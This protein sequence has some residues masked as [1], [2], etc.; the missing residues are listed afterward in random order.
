L[1][2]LDQR[3]FPKMALLGAGMLALTTVVGV[4]AHQLIKHFSPTAEVADYG[5]QIQA[6]RLRFIDQGDGISSFGGHVRVFDATTGRELAQLKESDGFVRAVLNSLA[7]ERTRSGAG[8]DTVFE[9]ASWSSH[10][11]TLKDTATGASVSL[12]QFGAGNTAAFLRF[13][14]PAADGEGDRRR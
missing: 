12:G 3:P 8:G 14:D 5:T 7:F 9:L 1:S 6:R 11:L 10:K 13:L 4:G 2:S